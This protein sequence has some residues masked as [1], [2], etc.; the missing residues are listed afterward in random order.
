[1]KPVIRLPT[2]RPKIPMSMTVP[3]MPIYNNGYNM[4]PNDNINLSLENLT[5]VSFWIYILLHHLSLYRIYNDSN[6]SYIMQ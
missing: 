3:N 6:W 5:Q 2:L 1:M 4:I